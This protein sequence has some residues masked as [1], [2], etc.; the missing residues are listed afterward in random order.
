MFLSIYS[1]IYS[2]ILQDRS[3]DICKLPFDSPVL[4]SF[5]GVVELQIHHYVSISGVL[6]VSICFPLAAPIDLQSDTSLATVHE[7]GTHFRLLSKDFRCLLIAAYSKRINGNMQLM[8][9]R[10]SHSNSLLDTT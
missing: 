9:S 5:R 3:L 6:W 8:K 10:H 7:R 1:F 4:P 2:Y